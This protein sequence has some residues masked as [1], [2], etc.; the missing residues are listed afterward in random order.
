MQLIPYGQAEE[1]L[2]KDAARHAL[3]MIVCG[4]RDVE[5]IASVSKSYNVNITKQHLTTLRKRDD[6][7]AAMHLNDREALQTGIANKVTRIGIL[8]EGIE[9][10]R[11]T[12][13]MEDE[14]T[15][16]MKLRIDGFGFKGADAVAAVKAMADIVKT[17]TEILE[18]K[19]TN[20]QV[21]NFNNQKKDPG[22]FSSV[23]GSDPEQLLR[24]ALAAI[25]NSRKPDADA[26]DVEFEEQSDGLISI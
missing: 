5:I 10:L 15:G 7:Q 18:P 11:N 4:K 19:T 21:N 8:E 20:V 3:S 26:I 9:L 6:V 24:D 22:S 14:D 1:S 13:V 17:A 25:Q 23:I 2:R 16:K 12:F